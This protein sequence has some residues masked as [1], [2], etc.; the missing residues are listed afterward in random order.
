MGNRYRS[1]AAATE[2]CRVAL[3]MICR[4]ASIKIPGPGFGLCYRQRPDLERFYRDHVV[5]MPEA[6]FDQDE[7][8]GRND[9]PVPFQH[10]GCEDRVCDAGLVFQAQENEAFGCSGALTC[11]DASCRLDPCSM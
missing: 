8:F 10:V 5:L 2:V 9:G 6:S 7:S 3:R 11:D 4:C 1:V